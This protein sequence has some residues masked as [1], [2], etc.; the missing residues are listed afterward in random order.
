MCI[1]SIN[2][3][4]AEAFSTRSVSQKLD[5]NSISADKENSDVQMQTKLAL[6]IIHYY[7]C[8]W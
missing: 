8:S 4:K 6:H 1:T 3:T 2:S 5:E 7:S